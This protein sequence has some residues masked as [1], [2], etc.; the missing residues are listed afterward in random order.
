M[1]QTT[2]QTFSFNENE[3]VIQKTLLMLAVNPANINAAIGATRI[4]IP[5]PGRE[6]LIFV[7]PGASPSQVSAD[8]GPCLRRPKGPYRA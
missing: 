3:K 2:A 6:V 4:I 5:C 8:L 1:M 7:G